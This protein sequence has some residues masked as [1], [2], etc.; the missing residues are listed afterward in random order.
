MN[1]NI[2]IARQMVGAEFLKLR[3]K[4]SLLTW[5]LLLESLFLALLVMGLWLVVAGGLGAWR[6]ATMDA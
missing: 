6:T 4:R 3:Y 2:T 1:T 5:A